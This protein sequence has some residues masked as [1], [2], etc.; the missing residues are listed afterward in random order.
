MLPA[1]TRPYKPRWGIVGLSGGLRM[2][3]TAYQ[4]PLG[5]ILPKET[6]GV[7]VAV[8]VTNRQVSYGWGC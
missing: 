1:D 7:A 8:A 4:A 3:G 2:L 5:L 6:Q